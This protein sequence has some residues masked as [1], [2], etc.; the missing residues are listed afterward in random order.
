[1][2]S[3]TRVP[4]LTRVKRM[5]PHFL[6]VGMFQKESRTYIKMDNCLDNDEKVS[7]RHSM[8]TLV[9]AIILT[10]GEALANDTDSTNG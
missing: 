6:Q 7:L 5:W 4:A 1:M 8:P 2:I 9:G 10:Q 3:G